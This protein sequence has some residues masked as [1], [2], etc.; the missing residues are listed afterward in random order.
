VLFIYSLLFVLHDNVDFPSLR[1]IIIWFGTR[2]QKSHY[3]KKASRQGCEKRLCVILE[4]T[5][6]I[7]IKNERARFFPHRSDLMTLKAGMSFCHGLLFWWRYD[8]L[9]KQ[10]LPLFLKKCPQWLYL[11]KYRSFEND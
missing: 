1:A 7:K 5:V 9:W 8:W 4:E 11:K 10:V 6:R 2:P 3:K